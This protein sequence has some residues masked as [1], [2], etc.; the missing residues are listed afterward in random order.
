MSSYSYM[1]VYTRDDKI[2]RLRQ[3]IK[4][5]AA[6]A[7]AERDG[8]QDYKLRVKNPF[9]GGWFDGFEKMQDDHR[10]A[11]AEAIL[12]TDAGTLLDEAFGAID[13]EEEE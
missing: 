9:A 6:E 11:L 12:H 13:E 10:K 5:A 4:E 7:R 1:N 3:M 8:L 2:E